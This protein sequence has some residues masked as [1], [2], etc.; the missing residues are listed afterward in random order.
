MKAEKIWKLLEHL[1]L[2]NFNLNTEKVVVA[3]KSESLN[4]KKSQIK[5]VRFKNQKLVV[6]TILFLISFSFVYASEALNLDGCTISVVASATDVSMPG[7]SNGAITFDPETNEAFTWEIRVLPDLTTIAANSGSIPE[8]ADSYSFGG[9]M[10]GSYQ[11]N[12]LTESGCT[13]SAQVTINQTPCPAPVVPS[14]N[15]TNASVYGANDAAVEVN[16]IAPNS[17]DGIWSIVLLRYGFPVASSNIPDPSITPGNLTYTASNL[18]A[19]NYELI[20]NP[21]GNLAYPSAC[22]SSTNFEIT[23]PPCDLTFVTTTTESPANGCN[24]GEISLEITG[25]SNTDNY[26]INVG[27]NGDIPTSYYAPEND[28]SGTFSLAGLSAGLYSVSVKGTDDPNLIY[29]TSLEFVNITEP[30]CD[31]AI[32]DI[33]VNNSASAG[34][35]SGSITAN[36]GGK[37][38]YN[39]YVAELYYNGSVINTIYPTETDNSGA[40][41]FTFLSPGD[42][43]LSVN[44]GVACTQTYAFTITEP[45]CDILITDFIETNPTINIGT[46]GNVSFTISGGNCDGYYYYDLFQDGNYAGSSSF[47][48]VDGIA[49]AQILN[50][51]AGT[52]Q[53]NVYT[54]YSF[55]CSSSK[56]FTLEEEPCNMQISNLETYGI[57]SFGCENGIISFNISGA[58]AYGYYDVLVERNGSY[59][60]N[61]YIYPI[62]QFTPVSLEYLPAGEYH[63]TLSDAATNP[64][65]TAVITTIYDVACNMQLLNPIVTQISSSGAFGGIM[66]DI[67]G[68]N[69]GGSYFVKLFKDGTEIVSQ[70]FTGNTYSNQLLEPGN[71]TL[72]V[73]NGFMIFSC[74]ASYNFTINPLNNASIETEVILGN[75]SDYCNSKQI[76]VAVTGLSYGIHYYVSVKKLNDPLWP[77]YASLA[78]FFASANP[79]YV[80]FYGWPGEYQ[81]IIYDGNDPS[82]ILSSVVE[83]IPEPQCNTTIQNLTFSN[84]ITSGCT[85]GTVSF[86]IYDEISC[87][88]S[89]TYMMNK[90]G[91]LYEQGTIGKS[92]TLTSASFNNLPIGNYTIDIT[93]PINNTNF[94]SCSAQ[95]NFTIL[96]ALC[97]IAINNLNITEGCFADT[98]S[99]DIS[100]ET[101]NNYYKVYLANNTTSNI[102]LSYLPVVKSGSVTP[103]KFGELLEGNYTLRVYSETGATC[104]AEENFNVGEFNCNLNIENIVV[105]NVANDFSLLGS[106]NFNINFNSVCN[107]SYQVNY[108]KD[109]NFYFGYNVP[110]TGIITPTSASSMPAGNWYVTV[111]NGYCSTSVSFV[112]G[113]GNTC[114]FTTSNTVLNYPTD[115]AFFDGSISY[116]ANGSSCSGYYYIEVLK[117]GIMYQTH[118]IAA[119][120]TATLINLYNLVEGNYT[121][122]TYNGCSDGVNACINTQHILLISSPLCDVSIID[123][124]YTNVT[125]NGAADGTISFNITGNQ[126]GGTQYEVEV[127]LNAVLYSS[128]FYPATGALTNLTLNNIPAGPIQVIVKNGCTVSGTICAAITTLLISEPPACNLQLTIPNEVYA[129]TPGCNDGLLEILMQGNAYGSNYLLNINKDGASIYSN[130][131][132]SATPVTQTLN[133]LA[134][135]IYNI[136]LSYTGSG[137]CNVSLNYELLANPC[138]LSISNVQIDTAETFNF[139]VKGSVEFDL[140]G[141]LCESG[142]VKLKR[143]ADGFTFNS[144]TV[145]AASHITFDDIT[146]GEYTLY[147]T[148]AACTTSYPVTIADRDCYL[149]FMSPTLLIEGSGSCTNAFFTT[150]FGGSRC[151]AVEVEITNISSGAVQQTASLF[152][153]PIQVYDFNNI[154]AGNYTIS[155]VAENGCAAN[156]NL[157]IPEQ[158]CSN[159][160]FTNVTLGPATL[161]CTWAFGY[162]LNLGNC[163]GSILTLTKDGNLINTYNLISS[164][165]TE[166]NTLTAGNYNLHLSTLSGCEI[167]YPIEVNPVCDLAINNIVTTNTCNDL[168][169]GTVNFEIS[170]DLCGISNLQLLD[171]SNTPIGNQFISSSGNYSFENLDANA[172][173]ILITNPSGCTALAPFDIAPLCDLNLFNENLTLT[174]TGSCTQG[175]LSYQVTG[176]PC[177]ANIV[178]LVNTTDMSVFYQGNIPE[179]DGVDVYQIENIPLGTYVLQITN[180]SGS[181]IDNFIFVINPAPC[182]N[183]QFSNVTINPNP[184]D[185]CY[186]SFGYDLNLGNCPGSVLTLNQNGTVLETYNLVSNVSTEIN[187]LT[188]GN[189]NLHL[190][191]ASGCTLDYPFEITPAAC[192][193]VISNE[194]ISTTDVSSCT[195]GNIS[196]NV[197]GT[198]CGTGAVALVQNGT[199]ISMQNWTT[200]NGN[201][202]SFMDINPGNYSLVA[203]NNL[204]NASCGDTLNFSIIENPCNLAISAPVVNISGVSTCTLGSVSFDVSGNTCGNGVVNIST[205]VDGIVASAIYNNTGNQSYTFDNLPAGNYEVFFGNFTCYTIQSFTIT[206]NPCNLTVGNITSSTYGVLNCTFGNISVE[207]SGNSCG[208]SVVNISDSNNNIIA[209][210]LYNNSGS[211]LLNF[212]NLPAGNYEIFFGNFSCNSTQAFTVAQNPCYLAIANITSSPSSGSNGSIN[213]SGT[214]NYCNGVSILLEAEITA[215]NWVALTTAYNVMST[216]FTG[217]APGNYRAT[218]SSDAGICNDVEYVTVTSAACNTNPVISASSSTICPGQTIVLNSNYLIGNVWSNGGTGFNTNIT[219]AGTYTLTVTELNG[220]TGSTS[221]TIN[222]GTNCVP[223]TQMSNGVCG[224]MNFVKTSSI[225]CVAV[226]GATQYEWQFSNGSGVYATKITSTNYVLL[227]SVT[228]VINWGTNWNI[229]VRAKIGTNV[230]PYSAD[231]NIGIM[232]D[233][234]IGGVPLTQLRTQDCGKLNYRINADNRIIANP[235]SGA[236]Q[237]EFEFSSATTGMIVA[238]KLQANNVLYLN[239]LTPALVFPAQYNVRVRARIGST[240]AVFGT[241]CLISIIGLNRE[242]EN[243]NDAT[244][245]IAET[246]HSNQNYEM[247]V[248]P[249]PFNEQATLIIKSD[250][251]E[252][253]LIEVFDMVGKQ[254]WS[255]KVQS[256]TNINFGSD[257]AQGTYIIKSLSNS[258]YQAALR[259]IKI[260]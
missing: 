103:F 61:Y 89:F 213:V 41:E 63:I 178:K 27:L 239:T 165:S 9:F 254:V 249:N 83:V 179:L 26:T 192:D 74:F 217:L 148:T 68:N 230:G 46:N 237:Y 7:C 122:N 124:F 73:Y 181:C 5:T 114:N 126:C 185:G 96:E 218:I 177:S 79:Q 81:F 236:I 72:E 211:Q 128:N 30:D 76:T 141:I 121:I 242:E 106:V 20:I 90:N 86:D 23:Q 147:F 225:T 16:F 139:C 226:S 222:A 240:W 31:I 183:T 156:Y 205:V 32:T 190:L 199:I 187:T 174:G 149:S 112:I 144:A 227:H 259:F 101:C 176:N 197:N 125:A 25:F 153:D 127:F 200:N 43:T 158:P 94:I 137:A 53:L 10:A 246:T 119:T 250:K 229:K 184:L 202:L 39:Y 50:L 219:S 228:P 115:P 163:P 64:C 175:N 129:S 15:I 107:N 182:S 111:S 248:M 234:T 1:S 151:H 221:I 33:V 247:M 241:P 157:N 150:M 17:C 102:Q 110:K 109:G 91:V 143:N 47:A 57:S 104:Y 212:I 105:T 166:I 95:V 56:I 168:S 216:Q 170:G 198:T 135:G 257:L 131:Y 138:N 113:V 238:T 28:G 62:G 208:S 49:N 145:T 186:Y 171:L 161:G 159:I 252:Q 67:V 97:D 160:E 35:N 12:I 117:D 65:T 80:N 189:Y 84:Q 6:S 71:Y 209:S 98:L 231:C 204:F 40:L 224:T 253:V 4:E 134:A 87:P 22:F 54:N 180:N 82:T 235:V 75:P 210:Q 142:E 154:P 45:A 77:N 13:G 207:V 21:G 193:I 162:D 99:F 245:I 243:T 258:G 155:A 36:I 52:Y 256:N 8:Y 255:N 132:P 123:V 133:Y 42:Y 196:F 69:C 233:P 51:S 206:E 92:G 173:G 214:G 152:P 220:C 118:N 244:E 188:T 60:S 116:T 37:T 18:L 130:S 120:G 58:T 78:T 164:I 232:A 29:C 14:I 44:N 223:A 66:A 38:C 146:P 140:N 34:C 194:V 172:Y 169:N 70:S 88:N 93:Q 85:N 251:D 195:K 203:V 215:G 55:V 3:T 11:V 48:S 167:D 24:Y 260:N 59:F 108:Y 2:N 191:T 19:G 136:N 201:G 100:G